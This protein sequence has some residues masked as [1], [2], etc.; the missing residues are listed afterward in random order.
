VT[1]SEQL[2]G[3]R[4]GG[5]E[6]GRVLGHGATA[7]V[8]EGTHVA[9][10]KA[11][12]I[13]ILHE[14]LGDNA[15][16][17]ERFLQEGRIAARLRHPNVVD[18]IDV[19]ADGPMPYLVMD[20]LEG[21]D[22][23]KFLDD[24]GRLTPAHA[25]ALLL[26]IAS[27]LAHAHDAGILHRDLKPSNIFL[28]RDMRGDVVP[29]LVDFGLSKASGDAGALTQT[30]LIAG[31]ALYMAPEQTLGVK[32]SSAASDQ[33][34]LA[35]VLYE[36]LTGR[37]PFQGSALLAL[38]ERI[39]TETIPSPSAVSPDVPEAL[40]EV[41]LRGLHREADGRF[42]GMRELGAALLPFA[43]D[44]TARL[45]ERDFTGR[46]DVA[47]RPSMRGAARPKSA[48][49]ASQPR[50]PRAPTVSRA[51]APLPCPAG[52]SPF[53]IKGLA[54]RGFVHLVDK[55]LPGGL[56]AFTQAVGDESLRPF[57]RQPFLAAARYD[58]LPFVP[59]FATLSQLVG[60][61]FAELVRSAT[62][63]QCRYDSRTAYR[64]IFS[65]DRVEDI[66]GRLSR[67]CTQYYDFGQYE[68]SVPQPNR[69][70]V[71]HAEIPE[72][73]YVWHA[74][75]HG[76]YTEE[77]AR[78]LGAREVRTVSHTSTPAGRSGAFALVTL[79]TEL[80]WA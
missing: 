27:A 20:L 39:R 1:L 65:S 10:G 33:Y 21:T 14:H 76:A 46:R 25:L 66:A 47:S 58:V 72:Y 77:C 32:S 67:F 19:G 57:L 44:A 54:Y 42:P 68:G 4:L 36:A 15:V 61:T 11:V 50:L 63:A 7:T 55:V 60:G 45:L 5:Y 59:L 24:A 29:T 40:A 80:A 71:I 43:D 26:P 38:L 6:I 70:L 49:A 3:T 75:M 78:I 2:K 13:K 31:T 56:D 48:P 62:A 12:A 69:L 16:V 28:A 8:F 9:L 30:A 79:R 23:R 53:H 52:T 18:V 51:A 34:A 22:L 35:A 17:R 73:L 41:V 64:A 37:P 74:P